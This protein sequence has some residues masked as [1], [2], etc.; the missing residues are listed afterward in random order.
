MRL[1]PCLSAAAAAT[2][3][4]TAHLPLPPATAAATATAT[5]T[6]GT[7]RV[8]EQVPVLG[9][10]IASAGPVAE[11]DDGE[12][13]PAALEEYGWYNRP[14]EWARARGNAAFVLHY[15]SE[16]DDVVPVAE[17]RRIRDALGG[18]TGT[19]SGSGS[20]AGGGTDGGAGAGAGGTGSGSGTASGSGSRASGYA[21]TEFPAGDARG[22]FLDSTF[23]ELV[24]DVVARIRGHLK[25]PQPATARAGGSAS[26]ATVVVPPV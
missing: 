23:P 15:H 1:H 25:L 20:G 26:G 8:A 21:Y 11:S 17:A 19:S 22:H 6:A 24:E 2:A 4:A 12:P 13:D 5:P 18:G 3:T 16:E 10:A 14:W 7:C 9:I